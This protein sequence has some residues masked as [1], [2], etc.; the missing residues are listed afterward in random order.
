MKLTAVCL[1]LAEAANAFAPGAP[2]R[3]HRAVCPPAFFASHLQLTTTATTTTQRRSSADDEN[4]SGKTDAEGADLLAEFFKLAKERNIE[5]EDDDMDDWDDEEDLDEEEAKELKLTDGQIDKEVKERVLDTAGG[6]VEFM[7]PASDD[8][9]DEKEEEQTKPKEYKPPTKI[10]DADLTA[11]EVVELVLAALAHNDVPSKN[12][13]VEILFAYSSENSQ[14][15]QMEDLTPQ[16]YAEYLREGDYKVLFENTGARIEKGEY[17]P[18]G[19]KAYYTA[20]IQTGPHDFTPVNFILS[21]G[22]QRDDDV[23][24]VDSMLIRPPGMRRNR[25]R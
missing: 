17:S 19:S 4:D 10:P 13:G 20:R 15:K 3:Q 6:F 18:D 2:R 16:E 21:T 23:W 12:K 9:D 25:R 8:E 1:L 14:V 5:L 24:M 11:G 22:G 7:K